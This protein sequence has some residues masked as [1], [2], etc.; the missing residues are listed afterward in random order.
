MNYT[1]LGIVLALLVFTG[2]S[3][4]LYYKYVKPRLNPNYIE[5]KEFLS[6]S[7][8]SNNNEPEDV[9]IILFHTLWCPH[10]KTAMKSWEG[11]KENMNNKIV[12]KYRVVMKEVDCDKEEEV[13]DKFNIE[14]YPTIKLV[15]NQG[16]E[17][18]EFDAKL[19]EDTYNEF[20][21]ATLH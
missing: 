5:N 16:K 20:L 13:A 9:E 8:E 10:S 17:I 14:G 11:I 12:N 3:V 15:K 19:S 2:V 21:N 18:I 6:E 4:F 7:S 1:Y